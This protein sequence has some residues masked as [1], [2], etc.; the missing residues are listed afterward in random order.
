MGV[1]DSGYQA[2]ATRRKRATI[3]VFCALVL[4]LGVAQCALSADEAP[5]ATKVRDL[6]YGDVL[7]HY[8]Q[9]DLFGALVRLEVADD[10]A[11]LPNHAADAELLSG[12]LYLSLGM[13]AEAERIFDR[14]LASNV[15]GPVS[16]RARFYL[17]RISYQ[18]G[19]F[20][21]AEQNLALIRGTLPGSLESERRLLAANVL[22]AL[23]RFGEAASLLQAAGTEDDWLPFARF[24]LGVALIRA[25]DP[26]GGRRWL[27]AVGTMPAAT[28]EAL[29]LRDRANLALGFSMLQQKSADPAAVA[30]ARV[31]LQGPFSNRALLGLG[32]AETDANRPDRALVPWL[33]LREG[34]LL[35]ASVQESFLAVPYAYTRLASN[36][37]AAQ[38]YR[39]AL[40]AY[41]AEG[42]RIDESIAAIRG[43][44][45]LDSILAAA[46][47]DESAGWFWQ[48]REVENAPQTRYLYHL[49]ASHEFQEGLKNYR[50]LSIMRRNLEGWR[51]S[52]EA[53]EEMVATRERATAKRERTRAENPVDGGIDDLERRQAR[54]EQ[55]VVEIESQ[56][57]IVALGSA[58]ERLQ[59]HA[60]EDLERRVG[61]LPPGPER[62]SLESRVAFLRG[63]LLWDLDAAYKLRLYEVRSNLRQ[64]K[65]MLESA[66]QGRTLVAAAAETAPRDTAGFASRI[67]ELGSRIDLVEPRLDAASRSQERVLASIAIGELEAQKRRLASYSTQAQFA[68]ATLYDGATAQA[69][70]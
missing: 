23:G 36:G 52:L 17:S 22:M 50:D 39:L 51:L 31:R 35:D 67:R 70:R 57:D 40:E 3:V 66:G 58:Q 69:A 16:D 68:L 4:V 6:D 26:E 46:P 62:A 15:P 59:W 54:L 37:Q 7:F 20:E 33:E 11:R 27:E 14:I 18:R 10:F 47:A 42:R 24:N 43:G 12:G 61:S 30:L 2:I 34:R 48:L 60:L 25:G 13:H 41:A 65:R 64:T 45:F 28:D 8:F 21:R 49:L 63:S 55:R 19:Y 38:Q 53:F 44:G 29:S 56:R 5:P 9:D 32:W 1:T